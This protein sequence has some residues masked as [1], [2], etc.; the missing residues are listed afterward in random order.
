VLNVQLRHVAERIEAID[1]AGSGD[2]LSLVFGGIRHIS[3]RPVAPDPL[4][5]A[6]YS[7]LGGCVLALGAPLFL[8][9]LGYG[10]SKLARLESALR[11]PGL[12]T[13][14]THEKS[15]RPQLPKLDD[16]FR[17]IRT[18][19]L[20]NTAP[21]VVMIASAVPAEGKT[22]VAINLAMAFAETG[23]RTLLIDCDLRRGRM[24]RCLGFRKEPGLSNVL[25]GEIPL[26]HAIRRTFQENLCAINAGKPI[27]NAA[28]LLASDAFT[29]AMTSLRGK[30]DVIVIDTPPVLGLA[31]TSAVQRH[32]D[33]VLFVISNDATTRRSIRAAIV[34]VR[35]RGTSVLGFVLN[36]AEPATPADA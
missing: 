27:P 25:L 29:A 19:L 17:T 30:Y 34:M 10:K 5:I 15:L 2:G 32:V 22:S 7:L 20:A 33:G 13:V 11:V 4:K 35:A 16:P 12:G 24:H 18:R 3:D 21:H 9:R 36:R 26:E 23:A 1:S 14:P 8:E 6:L 28:D 31:E